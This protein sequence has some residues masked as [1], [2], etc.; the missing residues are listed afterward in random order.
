MFVNI[1][2]TDLLPGK[3]GAPGYRFGENLLFPLHINP[4]M[5][6]SNQP[7]SDIP[8]EE[9]LKRYP[10]AAHEQHPGIRVSCPKARES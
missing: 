1:I 5:S 10:L 3:A 4:H 9:I 6:M 8:A 2:F 7:Y